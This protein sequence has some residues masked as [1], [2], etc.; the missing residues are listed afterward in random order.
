MF[1]TDV[2]N[3]RLCAE[4]FLRHNGKF[5]HRC[6]HLLQ[7]DLIVPYF[8]FYFIFVYIYQRKL[9]CYFLS[10]IVGTELK[11]EYSF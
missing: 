9:Y 7:L 10:C 2:I 3:G 11:I 4:L 6:N 5:N 1:V 8:P